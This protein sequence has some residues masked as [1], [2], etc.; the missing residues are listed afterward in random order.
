MGICAVLSIVLTSTLVAYISFCVA[1]ILSLNATPLTTPRPPSQTAVANF[2]ASCLSEACPVLGEGFFFGL[3]T[4][5]AHVEDEL[6]DIWLEFALKGSENGEGPVRAFHNHELPHHRLRFWT[7]PEVELD[8]VQRTGVDAYRLGIDWGRLIPSEPV[9]GHRPLLDKAAI[10]RYR[11][12]ME[13]ARARNLRLMVTL[14]HHS[15]P[16]WAVAFG[17]WTDRRMIT[18]FADFARVAK[19]EFGDLVDYWCTFNEPTLYLLLTHCAGVWPPGKAPSLF[20]MV[21]C[22]SPFGA[23][24]KG[25]RH[26]GEAHNLAYTLLREGSSTP[27]GVAHNVAWQVPFSLID[28]PLMLYSNYFLLYSWTDQIQDHLDFLG[29]NYYGQEFLSVAGLL[30]VESEEYSEAGRAVYPEGLFHLLL[31]FHN[32]YKGKHPTLRYIITENGMSDARDIIR[33][34]YLLEHL[35]AVYAAIQEG[36]PVDG[37]FHWTLSDNWEWADGYCPRF[38]LVEVDRSDNLKRRPRPS[39]Y[40]WTEVVKSREITIKQR[41][42]E[43]ETLQRDV[44]VGGTHPMCRA[45]DYALRMGSG[46]HHAPWMRK[47]S[48]KDWRFGFYEEPNLFLF[49]KRILRV[50][51]IR[52][53]DLWHIVSGSSTKS[54][55]ENY[56]E[57]KSGDNEL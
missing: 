38:G 32:R 17:G 26:V 51:W 33:R 48:G 23:F 18:Y 6:D 20:E 46:S 1:V 36:V 55:V 16:K 2:S 27:V 8:L 56:I 39:Y 43:W 29:L 44:L 37:Y 50:L 31:T 12:I 35:L 54:S 7:E 19:E 21:I 30:M 24:G 57:E 10:A 34:P 4:A 11:S 25:Q 22:V 14:F 9:D 13:K 41:E 53:G 28:A 40:L 42:E 52:L 15:I 47:I 5:P 45:V 3:A 49:S